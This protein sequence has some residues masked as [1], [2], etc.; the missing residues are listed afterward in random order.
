[1]GSASRGLGLLLTNAAYLPALFQGIV[2]GWP[3]GWN[4]T[5]MP[6]LVPIVGMLV[7][8]GL[9]WAGLSVMWPRK[10]VGVVLAVAGLVAVPLGF[11]QKEGL[12]VG[13]MV[14]PRYVLA[15][16]GLLMA[17]LLL[18]RRP[19]TALG[20]P[21]TPTIV[22]IAALAVSGSLA[23]WANAQRY[24]YGSGTG[25]FDVREA[26]AWP[27]MTAVPLPVI[28]LIAVLSTTILVSGVLVP[29]RRTPRVSA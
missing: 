20:L 3:L 24:A 5:V 12:G 18:D 21:P 10:A 9:A 4:D 25:L 2:G 26:P 29:N 13:E 14:Q 11:L 28:T 7:I 6:P 1:M 23:F 15:L 27:G 22:S 16:M 19:G 17:T 8:G